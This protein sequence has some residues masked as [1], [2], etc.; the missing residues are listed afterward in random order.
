MSLAESHT[1]T[2][3]VYPLPLNSVELLLLLIETR[4]LSPA[5]LTLLPTP[6]DSRMQPIAETE[7][8]LA[9]NLNHLVVLQSPSCVV[10]GWLG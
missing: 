4:H 9:I 10:Q 8:V 7:M 5:S 3:H 6:F 1:Y 2:P